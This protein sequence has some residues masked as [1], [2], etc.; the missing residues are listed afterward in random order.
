[1]VTRRE[2]VTAGA[3]GAM[4]AAG[5]AEASEADG[6]AQGVELLMV[7]SLNQ[8][9]SELK[10]LRLLLQSALVGPSLSDGPVSE[11]RRLFTQFLRANQKYPDYCEVGSGVFTELYDWHVR[12][13]QPIEITRTDG[14]LAIRFMFTWMVMRPE[15]DAAF[16]GFPYDRG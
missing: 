4:G 2:L 16:V 12:H 5:R 13:R 1:M 3:L 10:D 14:R 15:Q 11:A 7:Q 9:Q 8:I 6:D